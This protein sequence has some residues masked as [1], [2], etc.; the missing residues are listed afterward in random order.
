MMQ[1]YDDDFFFE[2]DKIASN[3]IQEYMKENNVNDVEQASEENRDNFNQDCIF[4]DL[5][6]ERY[7]IYHQDLMGMTVTSGSVTLSKDEK[8]LIGI[9]IGG[10]A[11][12]CPCLY[13]VQNERLPS[14]FAKNLPLIRA[15]AHLLGFP[16]LRLPIFDN[17]AASKDG[18]L[19]SG[20]ELVG[21]NGQSVKGKTKVEVAK[22]IQAAKDEVTINYNKL[23]ADP[24][25][26]KSLD[27]IMKKMKHRLVENMSSGAADALGLSRAILCNDTL[28][29][30][31]NELRETEGTYKRLVEYAKRML[32]SYF[33]LL[34]TYKALGDIF[35][36]IGV[37]EPQPRASEAFSKF[38]QYHRLLERDGIKMLKALKPILA[39]MGT[40]LNKAIPDTKLTIRKYADTKFEYLSYCLKV[41]EMD[42]EEYGYNALQEPLY[43]VE[44][45]NYEYRLIL[46]CRQ[47]ARARFARLRSDVLV[48]LELLDNKKTQDVAYQ[49]RRFIQGLAVYH[50]ETVEHLKENSSLFPVEVDLSQNAFQYKST[51]QIIQDNPED[52]EDIE[53]GKEIQEY[54]DISEDDIKEAKVVN[55]RQNKDKDNTDSSEQLL[56]DF[57]SM[58]KAKNDNIDN[59]SL[60]KELGLADT[61]VAE[62]FGDFQNGLDELTSKNDSDDIFDKLL[63]DLDIG[64]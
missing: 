42:D 6:Q 38:G 35:A 3:S 4:N 28:V 25:Q 56:P 36:A 5:R 15:S 2:E 22:M 11:P 16:S 20:D 59:L 49:L 64:K 17:T 47:D 7:K 58:D 26:G 39:D 37:R 40:Y 41:K 13:I 34:Q 46:R 27:I 18:T 63:R 60:L 43:R 62:E 57:D 21:V 48:K 23:H 50:N 12:L 61:N 53:F 33:D 55:R 52:E 45:G 29:A 51:T 32:K 9:S 30:K 31:L 24:N 8:N 19:Q 44:T 10:G 1:E 54:H 14:E